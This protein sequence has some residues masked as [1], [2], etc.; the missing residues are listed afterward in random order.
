MSECLKQKIFVKLISQVFLVD[1]T[2]FYNSF[3]LDTKNIV[4]IHLDL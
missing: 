3:Y 4:L 2:Q 1:C